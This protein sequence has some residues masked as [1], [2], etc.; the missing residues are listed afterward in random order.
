MSTL[1]VWWHTSCSSGRRP[2][3]GSTLEQ[4]RD[5]HLH[6]DPEAL[7]QVPPSLAALIDE[8][9]YKAPGARPSAANILARLERIPASQSTAGLSQ[10]QEANREEVDR[11]AQTARIQ[12]EAQ[13]EAE[14]RANLV[15]AAER[16]LSRIGTALRDA[17]ALAAPAAVVSCSRSQDG[18]SIRLGAAEMSLSDSRASAKSSRGWENPPFDVV[19]YTSVS[20]RIAPDRFGY[21]GRSHSLWYCDAQDPG[22]YAWFEAAFMISPFIARQG[23]QD[24]FALEPGEQS[25]KALGGAIAEFQVAWPF[26]AIAG[27]ETDEFVDRWAGWLAE[28]AQGNSPS[29]KLHA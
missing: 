14:R 24:P 8:C 22:R 21:E 29:S 10:L 17:V 6:A 9:L 26:A 27:G 2:F 19:S 23:R 11:R 3:D 4:F 15:Q 16:G 7:T 28:A 1:L 13:T 12:S 25:A 20:V 5:Q 18:W